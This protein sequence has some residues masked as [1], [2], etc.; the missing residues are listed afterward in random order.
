MNLKFIPLCLLLLLSCE[1][2][3]SLRQKR[4][5]KE[6][7]SRLEEFQKIKRNQCIERLLDRAEKSADSIMLKDAFFDVP[8]SLIVP[9]KQNRP[10]TPEVQFPEFEK[11]VAPLIDTMII[12]SIQ[13]DTVRDSLL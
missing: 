2:E 8:D 6:V 1:N 5:S 4:I 11:P 9:N 3:E 10:Q 13:K 7:E 12:D